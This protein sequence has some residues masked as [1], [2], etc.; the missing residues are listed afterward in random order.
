MDWKIKFSILSGR[1]YRLIVI[2]GE[3]TRKLA[4]GKQTDRRALSRC[5]I[6]RIEWSQ[7]V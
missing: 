7:F 2:I 6:K 5:S 3:T 1:V 4:T